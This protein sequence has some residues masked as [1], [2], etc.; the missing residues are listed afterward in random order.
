MSDLVLTE[1]WATEINKYIK[2]RLDKKHEDI[3]AKKDPKKAESDPKQ[4]I[5][6]RLKYELEKNGVEKET[7]ASVLGR[8]NQGAEK[9]P[10][11]LFKLEQYQQLLELGS[12]F[13]GVREIQ[14]LYNEKITQLSNEHAPDVWLDD[15]SPKANGVTFSTNVPKLTH[16]SIK[17][18]P[19]FFA[20]D[21]KNRAD[22]V[23]TSSLKQVDIDSAISNAANTPIVSLLNLK[24]ND[25]EL[26]DFIQQKNGTPFKALEKRVGQAESWVNDLS[27]VFLAQSTASHILLKQVYFPVGAK[28]H[29]EYHLLCNVNSSSLTHFIYHKINST[30]DA[31]KDIFQVSR[32]IYP[33]V[34][35]IFVTSSTKSHS[36]VSPLNNSRR[37]ECKLFCCAP[38][39]WAAQTKPPIDQKSWFYRGIPYPAVKTNIDYLRDFLLRNEKLSLSTRNPKKRKWLTK[40][41]QSLIDTVLFYAQQI[42]M[43]PAGWTVTD[44]IKLKLSQQYFLD[45]YRDDDIFQT[46]RKSSNWQVEI[47]RDFAVWLN[48]KLIGKDKQFTPQ[49]EHT[50]L[51]VLLMNNAL[52]ALNS[53]TIKNTEETA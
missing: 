14:A 5:L 26:K 27:Q 2:E 42:Q 48:G 28:N 22:V 47:S 43:L 44:D 13:M 51:W 34:N 15:F 10:S 30:K 8:K 7:I 31:H 17:N 38:P 25:C 21:G 24:V 53:E 9:I 40:W 33:N 36:N 11:L 23:C 37:G 32:V 45:P 20:K 1:A 39:T 6:I 19:S 29:G 16:P 18:V 50:K 3:L 4:A 46:A 35:K 41:G 12:D 49:A 52:R